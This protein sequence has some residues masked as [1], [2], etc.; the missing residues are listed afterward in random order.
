MQ[1]EIRLVRLDLRL[2]MAATGEQPVALEVEDQGTS[3]TAVFTA[4]QLRPR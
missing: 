2:E 4:P 1:Q 3:T